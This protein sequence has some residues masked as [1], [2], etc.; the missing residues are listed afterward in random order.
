MSRHSQNLVPSAKRVAQY[1]E[2]MLKDVDPAKAGSKPRGLQNVVIDTNTPTFVFGH[3]AIYPARVLSLLGRPESEVA[4][5]KV[6]EQWEALFKAGAPCEDD[7]ENT[8]YPSL[9]AVSAHFLKAHAAAMH[10]LATATSDEPLLAPF[11]DPA[12][13]E[14]FPT[15]GAAVNFLMVGHPM[16]H[17]GQVSAWRRC[18]GLGAAMG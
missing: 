11:P 16:V 3:L 4:A 2:L 15:V 9:A 14:V 10:A 7:V 6:S 5:I 1:A 17:L 8:K 13:R 18:M 12:R